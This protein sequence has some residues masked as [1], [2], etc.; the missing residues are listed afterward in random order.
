MAKS[1]YQTK[2]GVKTKLTNKEIKSFI[3]KERGW[4]TDQYNKEYDKLRNKL[5]AYEAFQA[6]SGV[7]VRKQSPAHILYYEA[8]AM[9]REGANYQ[10][11]I[12][13][14]RINS[15]SSISTG[16][17]LQKA[18]KNPNSSFAK[19]YTS[20]TDKAFKGL[21]NVN[22][23]ANKIGTIQRVVISEGVRR[24]AT[25]ED[26]EQF[27]EYQRLKNSANSLSPEELQKL[28]K[29]KIEI[30]DDY[31]IPDPVQRE[32]ALKDL[33]AKLHA[34]QD[35]IGRVQS[36]TAIPFGQAVGSDLSIDFVIENYL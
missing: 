9:K 12:E 3:M 33:A 6:Q 23:T 15:F 11:S 36:S 8:K 19:R 4:T 32:Q 30:V 29:I 18:L 34:R 31:L 20:G 2:N 22:P 25:S 24:I 7:S 5:R 27:R 10:R 17:A 16:K 21:I 28:E 26:E 13:L 35:A 1:I 14:E